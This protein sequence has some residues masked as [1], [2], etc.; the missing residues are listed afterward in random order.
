MGGVE[1]EEFN[2]SFSISWKSKVLQDN[3]RQKLRKYLNNQKCFHPN[4]LT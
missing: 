1:G 3:A 2:K 4:L